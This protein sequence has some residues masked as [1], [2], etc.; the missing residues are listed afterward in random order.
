M[1]L[2]KTFAQLYAWRKL[3]GSGL[4]IIESCVDETIQ[5]FKEI[6]KKSQETLIVVTSNSN[7]NESNFRT[8]N[9]Q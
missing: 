1:T 9:Q 3:G 5:G 8:E 2:H 7:V 4:V 6:T